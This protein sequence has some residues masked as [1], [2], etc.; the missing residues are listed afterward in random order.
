MPGIV[1][2]DRHTSPALRSTQTGCQ[3]SS[4]QGRRGNRLKGVLAVWS[5]HKREFIVIGGNQEQTVLGGSLRD[6]LDFP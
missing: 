3:P 5:Q 2:N 6:K 1:P 4:R